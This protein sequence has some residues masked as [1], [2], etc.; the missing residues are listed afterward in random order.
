VST[1]AERWLRNVT[2]RT[3]L[4]LGVAPSPKWLM[5]WGL[6]DSAAGVDTFSARVAEVVPALS[7]VKLQSPFFERFGGAGLK[8]MAK[9][10]AAC[11]AAGTLVVVDA[12]R[13]DAE[14]TWPAYA[15]LYLGPDSHI[16]GDALTV[17]P[18]MGFDSIVPLCE[19]AVERQCAVMVLIR[20][21]NH[22]GN[23]QLA[24]DPQGRTVAQALADEV[25]TFNTPFIGENVAGPLAALVGAPAHEAAELLRRLPGTLVSMPG[26]GRPHR[27]VA[28]FAGIIGS[29]R[30][31]IL[32]PVTSGLL[33]AGPHSLA[34]EISRW[35]HELR[36]H[37]IAAAP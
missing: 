13:G 36:T 8:A 21:S 22:R 35:Q 10:A 34:E 32:L 14:D 15:D 23:V 18:F 2:R 16:G 9:L 12:K 27:T 19:I 11:G 20:T 29:A 31:R 37:G 26:L 24:L 5:A 7:A 1:F 30:Q 4:V 17:V 3:S 33:Q 6:A 28:E 25:A